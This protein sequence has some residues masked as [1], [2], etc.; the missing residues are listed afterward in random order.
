MSAPPGWGPTGH[1]PDACC[2]EFFRV[3]AGKEPGD[4][5]G[6]AGVVDLLIATRVPHWRHRLVSRLRIND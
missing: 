1:W 3:I 5:C 6:M 2:L 4:F